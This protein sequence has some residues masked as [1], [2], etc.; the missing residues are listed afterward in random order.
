MIKRVLENFGR[1]IGRIRRFAAIFAERLKIEIAVIKLLYRSDEMTK[2]KEELL[3]DIGQRVYDMKSHPDKMFLSDRIVVETIAQI[4][5]I[6]RDVEDLKRKV[7]EM[8]GV[9]A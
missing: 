6:E 7:S 9:N 8:S 2:R 3:R 4:E 1:G 5:K